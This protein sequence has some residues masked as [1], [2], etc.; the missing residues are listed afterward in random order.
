MILPGREQLTTPSD[1]ENNRLAGSIDN[2]R[3]KKS[4][5][6]ATAVQLPRNE[7]LKFQISIQATISPKW[8][9]LGGSTTFN[10]AAKLRRFN[11]CRT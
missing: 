2:S 11:L 1:V 7:K 9:L 5:G 8:Q 4:F 3:P 6:V 10:T